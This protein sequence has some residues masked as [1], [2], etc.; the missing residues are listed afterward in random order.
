M[1]TPASPL[2]SQ[3]PQTDKLSYR[4]TSKVKIDPNT[5]C[6]LWIGSLDTGGYGMYSV[7]GSYRSAHRVAYETFVGPIPPRMVLDHIVCRTRRCVNWEHMRCVTAKVNALENNLGPSAVNASRV[8]CS[9]GH[10]FDEANTR[11]ARGGSRH[12]KTCHR[13]WTREWRQRKAVVRHE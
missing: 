1:N 7:D 6:W 2:F 10:P 3:R 12:C 13:Q 5:G 9:K 11:Y 8:A 4:F